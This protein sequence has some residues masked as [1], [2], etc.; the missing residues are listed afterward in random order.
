M[1]GTVALIDLLE[2]RLVVHISTL[3]AMNLTATSSY[4]RSPG[5]PPL[6][7]PTPQLRIYIL[8]P[9][10]P[11]D[12]LVSFFLL[13]TKTVLPLALLH[14]QETYCTTQRENHE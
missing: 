14:Q 5:T 3:L 6:I 7:F 2:K 13:A 8:R 11:S 9:N 1:F 10:N 4:P 12:D